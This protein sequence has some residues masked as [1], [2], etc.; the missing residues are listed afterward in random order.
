LDFLFF[1]FADGI[2]LAAA[3]E[4]INGGNAAMHVKA[5]TPVPTTKEEAG[6]ALPGR[7]LVV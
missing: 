3:S 5:M 6:V 7:E 4:G 2:S 1:F